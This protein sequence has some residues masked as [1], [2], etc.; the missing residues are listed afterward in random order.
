MVEV[1][2]E[3]IERQYDEEGEE[4]ASYVVEY[5]IPGY[6]NR[7]RTE[8]IPADEFDQ[9]SAKE[10]VATEA[11]PLIAAPEITVTFPSER[12]ETAA[13]TGSGGVSRRWLVL[14][15]VG[16]GVLGLGGGWLYSQQGADADSTAAIPTVATEEATAGTPTPTDT[17]RTESTPTESPTATA[18]PHDSPTASPTPNSGSDQLL[19]L[20]FTESFEEGLNGWVVNQRFRTGEDESPDNPT[21]GDGGHSDRFDGSVRLHVDGGPSTIGVA[22]STTGIAEGSKLT[23]TVY[24]EAD[25]G[26]PG[27]ISLAIFAPD[28]D[29]SPDERTAN[30]GKVTSGEIEITHTVQAEYAE[31]AEI[32]VWADVW[33]GEYTVYV[34]EITG[35]RVVA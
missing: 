24:V 25:G 5:T 2:I 8:P 3:N 34:Q 14:G 31:G 22:R 12:S 30:D 16:S 10:L 28:G 19:S 29:D 11:S 13:A 23:T 15:G 9:A 26:Q 4:V 18:V 21:P 6:D 17:L 35:H 1:P 32:R 7:Y 20:S 27:N 33:P